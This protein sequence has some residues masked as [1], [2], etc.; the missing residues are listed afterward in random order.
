MGNTFKNLIIKIFYIN[1]SSFRYIYK[2]ENNLRERKCKNAKNTILY[3]LR[4][5]LYLFVLYCRDLVSPMICVSVGGKSKYTSTKKDVG[6]ASQVYYGEH[7]FFEKNNVV[8][9]KIYIK[10]MINI[11]IVGCL[12]YLNN[13]K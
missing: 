11:K 13:F 12:Y 8:S 5:S 7:L 3:S 1:Y 9:Y 6:P 2:K 4:L 10:Y